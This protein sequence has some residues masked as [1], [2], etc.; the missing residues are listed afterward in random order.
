MLPE[1][2]YNCGQ[3]VLV[4]LQAEGLISVISVRAELFVDHSA[5]VNRASSPE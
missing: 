2:K 3:A 4:S 1:K 5:A